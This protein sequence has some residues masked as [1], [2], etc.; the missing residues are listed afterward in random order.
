MICVAP[1]PPPTRAARTPHRAN[2]ERPLWFVQNTRS[3]DDWERCDYGR[4]LDPETADLLLDEV[5]TQISEGDVAGAVEHLIDGFQH[6]SMASDRAGWR[7]FKN[8]VWAMHPLSLLIWQ[9]EIRACI[10]NHVGSHRG[11]AALVG[12]EGPDFLM[13]GPRY[14]HNARRTRVLSSTPGRPA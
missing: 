10:T 2:K 1:T 12:L 4:R 11:V 7:R 8:R 9:P 14:D 5:F 13:R 6:L 3:N